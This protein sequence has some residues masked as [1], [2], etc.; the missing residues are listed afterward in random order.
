MTIRVLINYSK[1]IQI[2]ELIFSI[3]A[4]FN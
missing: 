1:S 2:C 4:N 3:V